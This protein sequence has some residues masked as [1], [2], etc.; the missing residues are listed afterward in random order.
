MEKL[1]FDDLRLRNRDLSGEVILRVGGDATTAR[2]DV[3][4]Y[5]HCPDLL[6][7]WW[8][9]YI[10]CQETHPACGHCTKTGLK[11]EYP[12]TPQI[13]HQ[14]LLVNTEAWYRTNQDESQPHNQVPLFSLQDMR[15]FQHFLTQCYPHHPLKQEDIWTHEIPCIAH[16][17]C[18]PLNCYNNRYQSFLAR[19]SHACYSGLFSIRTHQ[20]RPQCRVVSHEPSHQSHKSHQEA[21]GRNC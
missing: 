9:T 3:S 6:S 13:T 21:I 1:P 4:K 8:L 17:V 15:F 11:C 2:D 14:V 5:D 18:S 12:S 10:K 20:K 19:I 16:N 7:V